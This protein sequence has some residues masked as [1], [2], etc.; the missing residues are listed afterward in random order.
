MLAFVLCSK[1]STFNFYLYQIFLSFN[2]T[3]CYVSLSS[4]TKLLEIKTIVT[5]DGLGEILDVL[6]GKLG[7]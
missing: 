1:R 2:L 6:L 7:G 3:E 4:L 5:T